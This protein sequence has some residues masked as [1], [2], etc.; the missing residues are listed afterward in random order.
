MI[1]ALPP[2][3]ENLSKRLVKSP[4]VYLR[5][6]G[7]LHFL[8]GMEDAEELPMH[9]R[10]GAS[11]KGFPETRSGIRVTVKGDRPHH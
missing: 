6:S 5:D 7:I 9:P 10:Y 11:W 3:L 2:W 1:R 8:P 4:K